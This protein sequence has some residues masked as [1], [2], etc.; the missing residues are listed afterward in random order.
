VRTFENIDLAT[1]ARYIDWTPYFSAWDLAG[2]Y[3]AILEDDIVGEAA[4]SLWNDTQAM[5]QQLSV[6]AG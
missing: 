6:K 3:P 4:T 5:M 1:L 2:K